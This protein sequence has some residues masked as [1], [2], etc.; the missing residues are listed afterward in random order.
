MLF[1][2]FALSA[3]SLMTAAASTPMFGPIDVMLPVATKG[4]PFDPAVNDVRVIFKSRSGKSSERLAF[5]AHGKWEVKGYLPEPGT[6]SGTVMVNGKAAG[7]IAS[8]M[9]P[10]KKPLDLIETDGK[11]FKKSNG[12]PFW[13][14]GIDVAW[15]SGPTKPVQSYFPLMKKAG[16][17]WSRVWACHW[18]DRNPYWTTNFLKPQ[19]NWMA[20]QALDRWDGV[21][22][23]AEAN[24]IH[25]IGR[26]TLNI[27]LGNGK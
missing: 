23:S 3:A 4:N 24:N 6:F 18:D 1:L 21:I 26:N 16:M 17:N 13:P 22:K 7:K 11:W 10:N 27:T 19:D 5:F 12:D 25:F 14:V 2:P 8:I 20:E 15:G 9:V